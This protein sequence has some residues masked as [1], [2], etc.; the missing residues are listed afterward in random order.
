MISFVSEREKL[1]VDA[2]SSAHSYSIIIIRGIL[3]KLLNNL[4]FKVAC[5][6]LPSSECVYICYGGDL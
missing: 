4:H 2:Q 1:H 5:L 6:V 3:Y